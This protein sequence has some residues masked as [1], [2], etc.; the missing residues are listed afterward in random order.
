MF[1]N[2]P[3]S[4]IPYKIVNSVGGQIDLY[5]PSI[6]STLKSNEDTYFSWDDPSEKN[7]KLKI[8]IRT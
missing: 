3:E 4:Q 7:K 6:L 5:I 1:E 2:L 8:T